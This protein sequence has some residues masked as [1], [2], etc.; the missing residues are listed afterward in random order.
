MKVTIDFPDNALCASVTYIL[1]GKRCMEMATKSIG[2]SELY[3]GAEVKIDKQE[4]K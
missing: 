1:D 3:D 2:T 4:S